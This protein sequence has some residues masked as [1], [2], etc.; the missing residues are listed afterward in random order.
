MPHILDPRIIT[1]S[2]N[3]RKIYAS[4]IQAEHDFC[5]AFGKVGFQHEDNRQKLIFSNANPNEEQIKQALIRLEKRRAD[6]LEGAKED[7]ESTRETRRDVGV[8]DTIAD[9]S[10]QPPRLITRNGQMDITSQSLKEVMGLLKDPA[11]FVKVQQILAYRIGTLTLQEALDEIARQVQQQLQYIENSEAASNYRRAD[12]Q[13][14]VLSAQRETQ[15]I[16]RGVADR[17]DVDA[18][19]VRIRSGTGTRFRAKFSGVDG[20]KWCTTP[21]TVAN[22]AIIAV[23]DQAIRAVHKRTRETQYVRVA[24]AGHFE[25]FEERQEAA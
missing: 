14:N 9:Q 18:L 11:D 7:E 21:F 2:K 10:T 12:Q 19:H 15:A 17:A 6:Y 8:F 22:V 16:L 24:V 5:D 20:G 3:T 13:K 23:R 1:L 25:V 4:M